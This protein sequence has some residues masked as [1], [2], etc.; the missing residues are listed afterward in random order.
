MEA[1]TDRERVRA[2]LRRRGV[3]RWEWLMALPFVGFA[4]AA[5]VG[6]FGYAREHRAFAALVAQ[7]GPMN[8]EP[9]PARARGTSS[10]R[11]LV[12]APSGREGV[13]WAAR[14]TTHR[15][16]EKRPRVHCDRASVMEV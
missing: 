16:G 6:M 14:L 2:R 13:A 4:T 15:S 1:V 3:F 12:G 7:S 9:G 8:V 5:V 10:R 11:P